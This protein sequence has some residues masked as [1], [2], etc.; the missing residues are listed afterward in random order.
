MGEGGLVSHKHSN[1]LLIE[2]ILPFEPVLL[3]IQSI[4]LPR[5]LLLFPQGA[6]PP[7]P[8]GPVGSFVLFSLATGHSLSDMLGLGETRDK[9]SLE[10]F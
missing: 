5:G 1:R 6:L 7:L 3:C 9:G 10:Y 4:K 8:G 2:H